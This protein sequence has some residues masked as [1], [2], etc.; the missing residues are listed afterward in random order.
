MV[1]QNKNWNTHNGG[2]IVSHF[3]PEQTISLGKNVE[4]TA[5]LNLQKVE[6]DHITLKEIN[7][8]IK[9]QN[10]TNSFLIC[11]GDQ[12]MSLEKDITDLKLLFEEQLTKQSLILKQL[13][14]N[15]NDMESSEIIIN[16]DVPI[17]QPPI[18]VEGFKLKSNNNEF[19]HVLEEKLKQMRL[20]VLS[21]KGMSDTS[22]IE[23]IDQLTEIFA[24]EEINDQVAQV[25][26][27]YAPKPVEKYYYKRPSPQDLLFEETEPFQ[28]SYSGKAIYEWNIDGL[29]DKQIIDMIH[30]II[31]Y[32]S[33]CKQQG[34]SDSSIASF[35]TTGFI[36]Q[37]RGWWDHYLTDAQKKEILSHKKLI[38]TETSSSST[39]I[40]TTGEE[41]AV[42]TLCLSILQHF[43][44]TNVPIAEKLQTLLQN[45]RC[46]SLTHFRW[47]KDTFLS[48]V[49]QL[50]NP[51]SMHWKSKFVDGLPHLFAERIRQTL[52]NNNDGI[53]I[54]Y[55]DLTY[56][57]IISTCINEGLSLCNDI[58]LKNQLK[59]QKLTEKHQ[60][61]EF[62]EQFAFDL[63][64]PPESRKKG[65]IERFKPY[66]GRRKN[67]PDTYKYSYKKK[68]RK[69]Y[70]KPKYKD[71]TPNFSRKRKAKKLDITCHK[72]GKIGHYANQCRTKKALN[73]I[74]DEELR[75][76]L[77]KV[78]LINSSSESETESSNDEVSYSSSSDTSDNNNCQCNELSYWKSI[79]EMNGLN[80]LT[81]EQ[82]EALKA[83]E[84]IS[85]DNLRRKL[86]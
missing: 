13:E 84:S 48:R 67:P 70:S 43:V 50:N 65:K 85:D 3:P 6:S 83:L 30:R 73:E 32:S 52:R 2:I 8:I 12:F 41:D 79:V 31:M 46:P 62:C 23:D 63:E 7:A 49:F 34:N 4:A 42:Y 24:N 47:Y 77:E 44:G 59:K 61:G 81:N 39:T 86:I 35:I 56:G 72:C 51:N 74:E 54:N 69:N 19:I 45:L 25:N 57:Q 78:L 58:K 75:N 64:K 21:Q 11:L 29:N 55:S 18:A 38:K 10:Y 71:Y 53:N 82:D 28:N 17:I 20:N 40:T 15:K 27:I 68:R 66:K 80:V 36:G 37:L 5:Y 76:Q 26:P 22:D 1:L 33:V 16:K 14:K 9:S 60:I